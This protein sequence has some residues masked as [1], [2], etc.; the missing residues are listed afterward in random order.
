MVGLLVM[1]MFA[2]SLVS[3][4]VSQVGSPSYIAAT[5]K[6]VSREYSLPEELVAAI[7]WQES[8]GR[9]HAMR[10]EDGFYRRYLASKGR[11][12]LRGHVPTITSVA[13]EKRARSISWGLMQIMGETARGVGFSEPW[14]F[15][16]LPRRNLELG[17]VYFN[18][19]LER[20]SR[21]SIDNARQY[22]FFKDALVHF[23]DTE[24]EQKMRYAMA[25]LR[26]NGGGNKRYP[27]EVLSHIDEGR[28]DRILSP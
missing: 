6:S 22:D 24:P 25:L 11:Q 13:T 10:V 14:F 4:V 18:S 15:L 23:S 16:L 19:L 17:C 28:I 8:R 12:D 3:Y 20:D 9:F 2:D 27:L 5:V 21:L 1:A 7:V 26:Y